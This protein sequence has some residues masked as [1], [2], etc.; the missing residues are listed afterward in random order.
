MKLIEVK[1]RWKTKEQMDSE[2]MNVP[3]KGK[4]YVLRPVKINVNNINYIEEYDGYCMITFIGEDELITDVP[5][6]QAQ[7][8]TVKLN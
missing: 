6:S 8:V 7:K 3:Y 5:Y 2:K 4:D 1:C